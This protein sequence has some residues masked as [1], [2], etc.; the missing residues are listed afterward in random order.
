MKL[1]YAF[2]EV[3]LN[4]GKAKTVNSKRNNSTYKNTKKAIV[5]T[6]FSHF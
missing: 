3:I 1:Y 5:F 2:N 4:R 6:L